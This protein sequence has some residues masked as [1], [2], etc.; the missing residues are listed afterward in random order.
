MS[1]QLTRWGRSVAQANSPAQLT[2]PS[3]ASGGTGT[4]LLLSLK[5]PDSIR[6]WPSRDNPQHV[7]AT[8]GRWHHLWLVFP[9]QNFLICSFK[10]LCMHGGGTVLPSMA[11][12]ASCQQG[13]CARH[14]K[15]LTWF[16]YSSPHGSVTAT[17]KTPASSNSCQL[18]TWVTISIFIVPPH[19]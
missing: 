2:S 14:L 3:S 19:W 5:S 10:T 13:A 6:R 4:L 7:S 18:L 16:C 9:T 15:G 11:K 8:K 12:G 1:H 17:R